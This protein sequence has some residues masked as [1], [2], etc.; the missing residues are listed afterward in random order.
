MKESTAMRI[1]EKPM[2]PWENLPYLRDASALTDQLCQA[3]L[4]QRW[5]PNKS[6]ST[7]VSFLLLDLRVS[8]P[9]S[10]ATSQIWVRSKKVYLIFVHQS[11]HE[12]VRWILLQ[13]VLGNLTLI[14]HFP[15][16]FWYSLLIWFTGVMWYLSRVRA[17]LV[18]KCCAH[19]PKK[20]KRKFVLIVTSPA[21]SVI[22]S[23]EQWFITKISHFFVRS[24]KSSE[25]DGIFWNEYF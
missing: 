11:C 6:W 13:F 7:R 9:T 23:L 21:E 18:V 1:T 20:S 15:W 5:L 24:C 16:K 19:D 8:S 4:K 2:L 10:S 25:C 12:C 17:Q 14:P 3:K 22:L